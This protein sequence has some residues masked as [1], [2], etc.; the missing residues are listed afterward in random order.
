MSFESQPPSA[1]FR[2]EALQALGGAGTDG[3][4]SPMVRPLDRWVLFVFGFL[5][6]GVLTWLVFGKVESVVQGRGIVIRDSEFG[7]FEVAGTTPGRVTEVFFKE[8]ETVAEGDLV[9]KLHLPDLLAQIS[10]TGELLTSLRQ[11]EGNDSRIARL[12]IA[13]TELEAM[14]RNKSSIRSPRAGRVIEVVIAPGSVIDAGRT[15]LRLESLAGNLE[16]L[17]YV[18]VAE[19]K[20]VKVGQ[21]VRIVPSTVHAEVSGHMKG[22]VNYVS[23]YPVTRDYLISELGGNARLTDYLLENGSCIEVDLDLL[24]DPETGEFLWSSPKVHSI[25]IEGGLVV[26]AFVVVEEVRPLS[27]LLPPGK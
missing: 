21:T 3:T 13:L 19:G 8:G 20:K 5:F 11:S 6:L 22:R 26:E 7:I 9:A 4:E 27:L 23:K 15:I 16:V 14:H 17:A 12:E 2:P 1:R 10:K 25:K 24:K 18:P